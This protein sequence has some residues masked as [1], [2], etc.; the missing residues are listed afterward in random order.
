MTTHALTPE[1]DRFADDLNAAI[2]DTLL[3][4]GHLPGQQRAS[5]LVSVACSL[6]L[7]CDPLATEAI[8]HVLETLRGPRE[9]RVLVE[10]GVHPRIAERIARLKE[11][12]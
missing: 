6:A 3:A 1:Q 5:I 8:E 12:I 7:D 9:Y 10:Q 2:A 11:K 4:H